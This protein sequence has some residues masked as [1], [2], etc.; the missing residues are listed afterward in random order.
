M[1]FNRKAKALEEKIVALEERLA[2]QE[3]RFAYT[4]RTTHHEWEAAEKRAREEWQ[5]IAELQ[6]NKQI[7]FQKEARAE[8]KKW[9]DAVLDTETISTL[10]NVFALHYAVHRANEPTEPLGRGF[11]QALELLTAVAVGYVADLDKMHDL[12]SEQEKSVGPEKSECEAS[13]P[14]G[15][16]YTFYVGGLPK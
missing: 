7:A 5:R 11:L 4:L 1:F 8:D 6:F 12:K 14:A 9:R 16:E 3:D 13:H 10:A 15:D 2:M